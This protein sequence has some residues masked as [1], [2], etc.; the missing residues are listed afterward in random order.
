MNLDNICIILCNPEESRNVG[1]VC[2]AMKNMGIHRLRIVGGRDSYNETQ[3]KTLAVHAADGWERAEFFPA[4]AVAIRDCSVAAGTTRRRG[5][6][7]K[8]LSVPPEE[9]AAAAARVTEGLAAA[10]F[11]N[12]RTGLNDEELALCTVAVHIPSDDAFP[13]L[14]LSHAVQI[15]AYSLFRAASEKSESYTP[16]TLGRLDR[17]VTVILQKLRDIGFFSVTG[18]KDMGQFWKEILSRALLSESEAKYIE[19]VFTKAA[20]LA[21]KTE[22]LPDTRE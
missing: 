16:V 7:R 4:L 18:E 15:V 22:K 2:R 10:V 13:S 17:T 19:N 9:F 21:S 12:E 1:S 20:G 6:N 5:N 3:V 14:N 8:R 11:G